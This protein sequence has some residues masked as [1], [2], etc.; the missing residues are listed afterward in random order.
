M[1]GFP[2]AITALKYARSATFDPEPF[3]NAVRDAGVAVA[4][5]PAE[6][7]GEQRLRPGPSSARARNTRPSGLVSMSTTDGAAAIE[8]ERRD[9]AGEVRVE[10]G[11][12]EHDTGPH[13]VERLVL[14]VVVL[15]PREE[16]PERRRGARWRRARS[17]RYAPPERRTRAGR[18]R[19]RGRRPS[20]LGRSL[21]RRRVLIARP[22]ALPARR[23]AAGESERLVAV[24]RDVDD[25]ADVGDVEHA[26]HVRRRRGEDGPS[27]AGL[28]RARGLDERVDPARVDERQPG[29]V[30]DDAVRRFLLQL[31]HRLRERRGGDDV[32]LA[33][34]HDEYRPGS[35]RR[36][37]RRCAALPVRPR[38]RHP[39][40][41]HDSRKVPRPI[42]GAGAPIR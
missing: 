40:G 14:C 5:D 30:D 36:R 6:T 37:V 38:S 18:R 19:R 34:Q 33:R 11:R 1:Y 41:S 21:C 17:R 31:G 9:L 20:S 10:Y 23:G 26:L 35:G 13:V 32:H 16:R 15:A 8:L 4:I 7:S 12:G 28:H 24:A 27:P 29:D 42:S 25:V 22:R 39:L 2:V 3:G